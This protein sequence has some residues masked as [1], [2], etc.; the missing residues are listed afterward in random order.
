MLSWKIENAILKS[1]KFD[2][3]RWKMTFDERRPSMEDD[4]RWKTTFDGRRPSMEDD[5]Q[6]KTTFDG[7]QPSMEDD[8]WWK[9]TFDGRRPSKE[10]DLRWKMTLE[11]RRPLMEDNLRWKT[12]FDER[13]HSMEDDLRWKTLWL[14]PPCGQFFFIDLKTT[15]ELKFTAWVNPTFCSRGISA[16]K[17]VGHICTQQ[18]TKDQIQLQVFWIIFIQPPSPTHAWTLP[19]KAKNFKWLADPSLDQFNFNLS[20]VYHNKKPS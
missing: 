9:T 6:W 11:G 2:I 17:L 4:L 19:N 12:T 3:L 10:D 13:R 15:D 7:R 20:D 5:L 14:L 1:W 18:T 16:W 8:L